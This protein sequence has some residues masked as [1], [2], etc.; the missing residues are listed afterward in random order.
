MEYALANALYQ[1]EEGERRVREA[2]GSEQPGLERAV[3]GVLGELRRRLGGSFTVAELAELYGQGTDWATQLAERLAAGS[4]SAHVVDAAFA[5]Y[6]SQ[7]ADYAGGR[8]Y[9]THERP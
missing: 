4:D 9:E 1:W 2:Q 3:E 8:R 7:G 5:R 6:A